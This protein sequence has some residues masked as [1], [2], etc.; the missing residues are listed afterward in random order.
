VAELGRQRGFSQSRFYA[1]RA[2][3]GG[4]E[5]EDAKRLKDLAQKNSLLKRLN[6]PG[7]PGGFFV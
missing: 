7:N 2:K 3:Y 4:V 5:T 6:R 1:W